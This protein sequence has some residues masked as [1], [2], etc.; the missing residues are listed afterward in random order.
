MFHPKLRILPYILF[1]WIIT[2]VMLPNIALC[3][4]EGLAPVQN[5]TDLLLPLGIYIL[6]MCLSA[7]VGRMALWMCIPLFLA[8][9]ELVLLYLYGNSV[10]AV[11]MWLNLVTTNSHEAV[12]LLSNLLPALLLVGIL[13]ITPV[14]VALA[15]VISDWRI[16][17]AFRT[18]TRRIAWCITGAGLVCMAFS[19]G[20]T[21]PYNPLRDVFPVNAVSNAAIAVQRFFA[22]ERYSDTSCDYIFGAH[23]TRSDTL[24]EVYVLVIGE[25]SRAD[26]WESFGYQRPTNPGWRDIEGLVC[27]PHALSE[28]NTTHKSVPLLLSPLSANEFGDSINSVKSLITAF[29]ESGFHTAFI[30]GQ[31]RNHSYID[32]F[33]SEADTCI[34]IRDDISDHPVVDLD[35]LPYVSD[36]LQSR[37]PKLLIVLHTY[38]SHFSYADRYTA[39][40]AVFKPDGPVAADMAHKRELINAY[41]NTIVGTWNLLRSVIDAVEADGVAAAVLYTSDHGEDLFDDSR[42]LLLH[43]SPRPTFY[44]L[45]VPYL[46]WLSPDY[47]KAFPKALAIAESN[48]DKD[49][50]SSESFFHTALD[51]ACIRYAGFNDSLSVLSRHYASPRRIYLDDHNQGV[52]LVRSGLTDAD[53]RAMSEAGISME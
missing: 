46:V 34:F 24:P 3:F 33:G 10:I 6:I 11:D 37:Y 14:A 52:P 20:S 21:P 43:A 29:R 49:I 38:G 41:D 12:E 32:F 15:A 45:H 31:Q 27:Y 50:A 5:A 17:A 26:H 25:T 8:G 19:F 35:L 44:Q 53:F 40:S 7:N 51:L 9:F 42:H 48:R 4:T 22:A 23:S 1:F 39:D 13:Y 36:Q 28:S 16:D 18:I 2:V 47:R 30:S